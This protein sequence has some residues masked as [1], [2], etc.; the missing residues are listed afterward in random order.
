MC[1]E[2]RQR[3]GVAGDFALP[4][5]IEPCAHH[6]VMADETPQIVLVMGVAGSGKTSVGRQ[7]ATELGWTFAEG[8]DF[9]SAANVAKMARGTPLTDADRWPWLDA[10]GNWIAT[11]TA[12]G[13]SAV[14][15][16]S[17]LKRSYRDRLRLAWSALRV[18]YLRVDRAELHRRLA[19][20]LEHF[21]PERLLDSQLQELEPPEAD[22]QPIVVS[23]SVDTVVRYV[24]PF[25]RP[26]ASAP[27]DARKEGVQTTGQ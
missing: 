22:E 27:V 8:D 16:C 6:R 7:L 19:A 24:I 10:I 18:V 21:F 20:R 2:A 25:L 12:A 13:R 1:I 9:H 26:S 5:Q 3:G 4:C 17:A 11:E 14:V 15:A 23:N